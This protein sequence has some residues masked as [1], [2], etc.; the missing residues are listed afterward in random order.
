MGKEDPKD[1]LTVDSE[2]NYH[3]DYSKYSDI[4]DNLPLVKGPEFSEFEEARKEYAI[5]NALGYTHQ[6]EIPEIKGLT[7]TNFWKVRFAI[8][9]ISLGF[10]II[11]I[12]KP[13]LNDDFG[14]CGMI[15]L[16]D[17]WI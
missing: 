6:P 13:A 10:G 2:K 11:I 1:I 9:L 14:L 17:V 15:L 8:L 12:C 4:F 16:G 5:R 7:P 3:L